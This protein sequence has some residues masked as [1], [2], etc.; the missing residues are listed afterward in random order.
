[1]QGMDASLNPLI[2]CKENA[3]FSKKKAGI[4]KADHSN[5]VK[6]IETIQVSKYGER[7]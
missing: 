1:M 5:I 4:I 7:T 3:G 2:N 6:D